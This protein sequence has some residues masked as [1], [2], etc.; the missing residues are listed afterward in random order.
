MTKPLYRALG[1]AA[2]LP[3]LVACA[4]FSPQRAGEQALALAAGPIGPAASENE[5]STAEQR[6]ALLMLPLERE[7]AVSLALAGNPD[8]KVAWSRL[9]IGAAEA[10][11][12]SR[13]ANPRLSA[14]RLSGADGAKRSM[15]LGLS[16][17]DLLLLPYGSRLAAR[18]FEALRIEV[19]ARAVTVARD[20]E[21]AWY[22]HVAASQRAELRSAVADAAELSA[23][24]ADRFHQAG[25]VSRLQLLRERAAASEARVAAVTARADAIAAR[26]A[27]NAQMGLSGELADLWQA[28]PRLAMPGNDAV[29]LEQLLALADTERLD[30]RAARL[31]VGILE[32]GL[33]FSRGWR[34]LGGLELD[35]EWER[36]PDGSRMRGPG[37]S[38]ELPVFHQGQ[39]R[40][41]RA[42][43]LLERGRAQ[44]A[45]RELEVELGARE[46]AGRLQATREVVEL[47]QSGI[48]PDRSEAVQ[49]EL[50]RYNFML[51]GAFELLAA[52]QAEYQAYEGFIDAVRDYWLAHTDLAH[53]IGARLPDD[54]DERSLTPDLQAVIAPPS[55]GGHGDHSMHGGDNDAEGHEGHEGHQHHGHHAP[56][57]TEDAD[58]AD[59]HEHDHHQGH[60]HGDTP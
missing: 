59:H 39:A 17:A 45:Q 24:L 43:A 48:V 26:Q 7:H 8:L 15:S 11:E 31:Q 22:R 38:L 18:D 21:S 41:M 57:E 25:T 51:I 58:D 60:D 9:G 35:Y 29:E 32:D 56:A 33:A 13:M 52:R 28:P 6:Q 49:R 20:T 42:D 55:E 54:P 10:F 34:W 27:L 19:A 37:L 23:E 3:A 1:L 14:T 16:I 53:A 44:L 40:T 46:A 12:A 5:A 2:L 4:S 50:E 36:E 30:L 47:Y